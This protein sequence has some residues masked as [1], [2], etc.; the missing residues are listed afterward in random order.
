MSESNTAKMHEKTNKTSELQ[1]DDKTEAPKFEE[2]NYEGSITSSRRCTI[3]SLA[4]V[5]DSNLMPFDG[6]ASM[7]SSRRSTVDSIQSFDD[8][9]PSEIELKGP[10]SFYG[11]FAGLPININLVKSE[12]HS[13]D[14]STATSTDIS[15]VADMTTVKTEP[16]EIKIEPRGIIVVLSRVRRVFNEFLIF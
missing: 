8:S 6:A 15:S 9:I 5:K 3:D 12:P 16:I 14:E 4:S 13:D 1:T 10:P 7:S 11:G 2:D